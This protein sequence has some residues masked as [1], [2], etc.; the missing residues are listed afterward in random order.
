[1]GRYAK[2]TTVSPD[3]SQR[4][5]RQTVLRYG[6]TG[7]GLMEKTDGRAAVVFEFEGL[8]I[9]IAL[10]IPPK[11]SPEFTVTDTGRDRN[12]SRAFLAWEKATRQ[13]WR[14][15]LLVIRAKLEAVDAGIST[16]EREFMP[17]VVCGPGGQTLGDVLLPQLGQLASSGRVPEL[18]PMLEAAGNGS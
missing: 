10:V 5:I 11:D 3:R 1:M 8:T 13:R 7:F 6:A 17:F 12:E 9:Q 4:E 18:L 2:D 15:L 16:I 14:A